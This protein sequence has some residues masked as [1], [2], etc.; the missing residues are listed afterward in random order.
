MVPIFIIFLLIFAFNSL[1]FSP[2]G[3]APPFGV[4]HPF[5]VAP[6]FGAAPP[7]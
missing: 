6:P 4:A 2:F 5:G 3:V 7:F 1:K